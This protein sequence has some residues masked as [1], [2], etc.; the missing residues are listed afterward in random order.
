MPK[1]INLCVT[2]NQTMCYFT[3][4]FKHIYIKELYDNILNSITSSDS[5]TWVSEKIP[6][7]LNTW[8]NNLER[9][10]AA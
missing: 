4:D 1:I 2:N 6:A 3:K 5:N 8:K 9:S 10:V 7:I